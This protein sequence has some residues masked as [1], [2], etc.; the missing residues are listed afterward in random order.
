MAFHLPASSRITDGPLASSPEDGQNGAFHLESVEPGWMLFLI[1]SDSTDPDA[2]GLPKW[3]HVSVH[4][5]RS[6]RVR[7]PTWKE[8]CQVKDRRWD[9]EDVVMQLHPRRSEYVNQHPH[10]LHLWRPKEA[11]IPEPPSIFVGIRA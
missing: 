5:R 11:A 1:G 4:A 2:E 7:T 3:E 6:D 8:M 10:V 9:A